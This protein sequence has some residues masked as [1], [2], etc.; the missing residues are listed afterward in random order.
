MIRVDGN[1]VINRPVEEV[2][3]YVADIASHLVSEHIAERH[4]SNLRTERTNGS[5]GIAIGPHLPERESGRNSYSYVAFERCG[6]RFVLSSRFLVGS[7]H[8]LDEQRVE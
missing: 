8:R 6:H 7:I 2:G 1:V 3:R 4:V 5:A